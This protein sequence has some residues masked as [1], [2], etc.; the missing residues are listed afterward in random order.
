MTFREFEEILDR[1]TQD[2]ASEDERR[3]VEAWFDSMEVEIGDLAPD[4][5]LAMRDRLWANLNE[6][7]V[8]ASPWKKYRAMAAALLILAVSTFLINRYYF[9]SFDKESALASADPLSFHNK[10]AAPQQIELA[11]GTVITLQPGG[12]I[13]VPHAFNDKREVELSGEAF[14]NVAHDPRRPFLVYSHGVTTKVL[15][16]SFNIQAPEQGREV[17]V[18]VRTGRVSVLTPLPVSGSSAM[19]EV[20]LN[21]NQEVVYKLNGQQ[22]EKKLVDHPQMVVENAALP[23]SYEN[24]PVARI[25]NELENTYGIDIQYD[26]ARLSHCTLTSDMSEE[27][28]Y[29][30]I[31]IVCNAIGARYQIGDTTIRVE[32]P[33]CK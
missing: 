1:Y 28:L 5:Q 7:E 21:P 22:T 6:G 4:T 14:F 10:G 24:E 2:Q 30:R 27:G 25:L 29:E 33:G 16:T 20:I 23:S 13:V 32:A 8:P 11:D 26:A 9:Q 18:S 15:G 19:K 31:E 17:I 12:S 3:L